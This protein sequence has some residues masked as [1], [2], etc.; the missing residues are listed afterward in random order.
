M[1]EQVN[2]NKEEFIGLFGLASDKYALI[3]ENFPKVDFNVP[4]LRTKFYATDLIGIFCAG[5][6]NGLLISN[7][8][9]D[10]EIKKIKNFCGELGINVGVLYEDFNALGNL[11]A[12]NDKGALVSSR[13]SNIKAVEDILGV[14]CV[15]G[16]AGGHDEVGSCIAA[17]NKGFLVHPDA[18]N[19]LSGLKE[20]KEIF[21]VSGNVGSVNLG[22][23]YVR[24]GIIANS[25]LAFV[26][27]KTT[28]IEA[29]RI[30]DALKLDFQA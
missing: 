19:E 15:F 23:P 16:K 17:T 20:L 27:E 22:V 9:K 13:I 14:E 1:I 18:E 3:S 25:F 5:N 4:T 30:S 8:A 10:S 26:G 6:S 11:I 12:C 2:V 7:F 24:S 29:D 21:G 28:Y